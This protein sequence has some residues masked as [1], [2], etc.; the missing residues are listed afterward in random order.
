MSSRI[1][2]YPNIGK[3]NYHICFFSFIIDDVKNFVF[4]RKILA[5]VLFGYHND[6]NVCRFIILLFFREV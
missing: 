1:I 3:N 4:V 2:Y 5:F 6:S